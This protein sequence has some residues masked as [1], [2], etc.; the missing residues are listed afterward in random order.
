MKFNSQ[1][2]FSESSVSD[3]KESSDSFD[4]GVNPVVEGG[5]GSDLAFNVRAG[6]GVA[7][8]IDGVSEEV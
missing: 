4:N 8:E 7:G 6:F 5:E 3:D 2:S 1:N